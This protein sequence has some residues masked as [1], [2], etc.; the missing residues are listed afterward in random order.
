MPNRS[1]GPSERSIYAKP[2]VSIIIASFNAEADL[3][4]C[5]ESIRRQSYEPKEVIVIDGGSTDGTIDLLER[6]GDTISYWTSEPDTGIYSAW[7]KGLAH[8]KGQWISFIGADDRYAHD[9][10]LSTLMEG[11]TSNHLPDIVCSKAAWVDATGHII[12]IGGGPWD[13]TQ[14]KRFQTVVHS[15][16]LQRASLFSAHGYFSETYKIAGDYEFL[17]RLGPRTRAVFID[18]VIMHLGTSG[19]S[20]TQLLQAFHERKAVQQAHPEIGPVL[21][22]AIFLLGRLKNL[23]RESIGTLKQRE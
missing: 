8:T 19:I 5:I 14:M 6:C 9:E 16:M 3:R 23:Y 2:I 7:N 21:P 12:E 11:A 22:T 4:A 20:R 10:C 18:E 15:G 17:L 1:P 13:W